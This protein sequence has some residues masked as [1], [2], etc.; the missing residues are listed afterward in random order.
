MQ[1][2]QRRSEPTASGAPPRAGDGGDAGPAGSDEQ[3]WPTCAR[4]RSGEFV[5]NARTNGEDTIIMMASAE[6][7]RAP[8]DPRHGC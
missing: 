1:P 8:R 4:P 7:R 3:G 6:S 5:Q 2:E